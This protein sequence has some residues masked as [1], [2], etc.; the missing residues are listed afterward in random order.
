MDKEKVLEWLAGFQPEKI[1]MEKKEV[2]EELGTG[3]I[4]PAHPL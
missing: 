1:N 4:D 2:K 3:F